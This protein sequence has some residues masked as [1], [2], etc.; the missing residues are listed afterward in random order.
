MPTT[1]S[2]YILCYYTLCSTDFKSVKKYWLH[3]VKWIRVFAVLRLSQIY[4]LWEANHLHSYRIGTSYFFVSLLETVHKWIRIWS[5]NW[6]DLTWSG[7]RKDWYFTIRILSQR[8]DCV[9]G[10]RMNRKP[11][12]IHSRCR[13]TWEFNSLLAWSILQL[14]QP[15]RTHTMSIH[16]SYASRPSAMARHSLYTFTYL[17][18]RKPVIICLAISSFK[19]P[20]FSLIYGE[21]ETFP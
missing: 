14:L 6:I 11:I 2:P 1:L 4:R 12:P 3:G 15:L 9:T 10:Q 5:S 18:Q 16:P 17:H 8:C 13:A 21:T 19:T 7:W 20:K